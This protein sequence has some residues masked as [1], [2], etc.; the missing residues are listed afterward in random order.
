METK[1]TPGDWAV[2]QSNFGHLSVFSRPVPEDSVQICEMIAPLTPMDKMA[3]I[4]DKSVVMRDKSIELA[5]LQIEA[6]ANLIALAPRMHDLL[7]SIDY[8]QLR[9]QKEDLLLMREVQHAD[10]LDG[11]IHLIDSIQDFAEDHLGILQDDWYTQEWKCT[12]PDTEQYGRRL[13]P[14]LFEFKQNGVPATQIDLTQYTPEQIESIINAY[15]YTHQYKNGFHDIADLYDKE[16]V[17]IMAECIF[18]TE[19]VN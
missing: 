2:K 15:G 1:H 9:Q 7:T 11:I 6:N 13:G 16:T 12:D 5:F 8:A 10:A 4:K 17:W 3:I 19:M 14:Q 18:E